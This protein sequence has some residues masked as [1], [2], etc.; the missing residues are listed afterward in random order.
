MQG[1]GCMGLPLVQ[2]RGR[3]DGVLVM[4][5]QGCFVSWAA[6]VSGVNK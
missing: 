3:A 5:E 2:Q 4:P 6:Y 1:R